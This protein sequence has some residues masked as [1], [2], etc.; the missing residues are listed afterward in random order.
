MQQHLQVL[1]ELGLGFLALGEE[2]PGLSGGEAQR[3]MLASEM[4]KGQSDS[5]FVFDEPT[6]GLYPQDVRTL[7]HV[8]QNMIDHGATVVAIG[9]DLDVIKMPITSSTWDRAAERRVAGSLRVALL[10]KSNSLMRA[11]PGN[12][13]NK[14]NKSRVIYDTKLEIYAHVCLPAY[15]II[16]VQLSRKKIKRRELNSVER[17]D[18]GR[19]KRKTCGVYDLLGGM[20]IVC[21]ST[22]YINCQS[23]H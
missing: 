17:K 10:T 20:A 11:L 5:I 18:Y 12:T 7:L 1:H 2:T 9:H 21:Y 14:V 16:Y 15:S 6:I 8:F 22:W 13:Y 4:G 3:L 19:E 23:V